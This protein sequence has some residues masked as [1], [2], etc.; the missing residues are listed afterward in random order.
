MNI[1]FVHLYTYIS[2]VLV[3]GLYIT[4]LI[5]L[6]PKGMEIVFANLLTQCLIKVKQNTRIK[7]VK[8][9]FF[10]LP[11]TNNMLHCILWV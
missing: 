4:D 10:V 8:G 5:G 9:F 6:S 3:V 11:I 2:L 1:L 7:A